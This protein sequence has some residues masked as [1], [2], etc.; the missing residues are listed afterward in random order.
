MKNFIKKHFNFLE[1]SIFIIALV[2]SISFFNFVESSTLDN[3]SGYGWNADQTLPDE[4]GGMGWLSFNCTSG[5]DCGAVDYGVNIDASGNI[6]G[7]AWSS[8]YGWLKFG[9]LSGFPTSGG[10][11]PANAK[12]TGNNVTGWAR[13]CSVADSPSTCIGWAGTNPTNG[14]W[15]GWVSLA[16][17]APNYG[18]TLSGNAFSGY[19]WGGDDGGKNVVGWIDFS[20][21]LYV[22][23]VTP[24]VT[25]GASP[26][27]V[28]VGG[29]TVISWNGT[30]L[31]NSATGCTASGGTGSW[32]GVRPSPSGSFSTG[33]L[34]NGTYNYS[35]QC[36][37][38]NGVTMSNVAT[39]QVVVGAVTGLDFYA[40]P[41][42]S[43][44]PLYQTT[45]YWNAVPSIPGLTSCVADSAHLLTQLQYLLGM[46]V[47]QIHLEICL[48]LYPITLQTTK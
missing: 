26:A 22:P 6:T 4:P 35:I 23:I 3:V 44:P 2:F 10:T 5:G 13:F 28:P 15:D 27:S 12:L 18:V 8:N 45:L 48:Y 39:V 9:G 11:T 20:Q 42:V 34:P 24:T 30:G 7:Y 29:S 31:I 41:A 40:D 46:E 14:G 43:Y 21:A 17:T 1:A 25:I 16:G 36:L 32:P 19:A 37:G 33:V 38:A 47:F